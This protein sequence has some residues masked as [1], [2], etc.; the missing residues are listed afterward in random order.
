MSR[1]LLQTILKEDQ[2]QS[3]QGEMIAVHVYDAC[4]EAHGRDAFR[5]VLN[6]EGAIDL[7]VVTDTKGVVDM[8]QNASMLR[9]SM[10][11]FRALPMATATLD[12]EAI[13]RA[14]EWHDKLADIDKEIQGL[15]MVIVECL[16]INRPI[17]GTSE[18]ALPRS[19]DI[20][21]YT[22]IITGCPPHG[23]EEQ[24]NTVSEL[25]RKA[26]KEIL[27]ESAD[28]LVLPPG[29]DDL[30]DPKKTYSIHWDKLARLRKVYDPDLR[31]KA[32]VTL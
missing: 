18:V 17:G 4:G 15:S 6:L 5:W 2:M 7:T 9:G 19:D 30:Q 22:L 25:V 14:M 29:L 21:H 27:G 26:P 24:D 10:A 20:K 28:F 16:V 8:Q 23:T 32:L 12:E 13:V 11:N 1:S 31:F 3:V